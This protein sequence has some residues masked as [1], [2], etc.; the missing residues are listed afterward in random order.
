MGIPPR[1]VQSARAA[2][3]GA[4]A[5]QLILSNAPPWGKDYLGQSRTSEAWNV[6]GFARGAEALNSASSAAYAGEIW[7]R[8]QGRRTQS[9]ERS[10]V[11][12]LTNKKHYDSALEAAT[13][14]GI[15]DQSVYNSCNDK[16]ARKGFKFE[17]V[18]VDRERL[19]RREQG[20]TLYRRNRT[21]TG[22]KEGFFFVYDFPMMLKDLRNKELDVAAKERFLYMRRVHTLPPTLGGVHVSGWNDVLG[23]ITASEKPN[24]PM[25][26]VIL[27]YK[28]SLVGKVFRQDVVGKIYKCCRPKCAAP[29]RKVCGGKLHS[30]KFA[31][32]RDLLSTTPLR[33]IV[34][35]KEGVVYEATE[36][37]YEGRCGGRVERVSVEGGLLWVS[38]NGVSKFVHLVRERT[39]V[40][41]RR[42]TSFHTLF[43]S[44]DFTLYITDSATGTCLPARLE[45]RKGK[46]GSHFLVQ[47][48]SG[49]KKKEVGVR[50]R[51]VR[52]R[53]EEGGWVAFAAFVG[54]KKKEV[55]CARAKRG[56]K[57]TRV[58][59]VFKIIQSLGAWRLG[60]GCPLAEDTIAF[61]PDDIWR[62]AVGVDARGENLESKLIELYGGVL[63]SKEQSWYCLRRMREVPTK[64]HVFRHVCALSRGGALVYQPSVSRCGN[65]DVLSRH[66]KE[67]MYT[68]GVNDR[69]SVRDMYKYLVV[70][71]AALAPSSL[72]ELLGILNVL[73]VDEKLVRRISLVEF[74]LLE[75]NM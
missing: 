54:A 46:S 2:R 48:A 65:Y 26:Q 31:K 34:T 74:K 53:E 19:K 60:C 44:I 9:K 14:L 49:A 20:L 42:I 33:F 23:I 41:R 39:L 8:F 27:D 59:V 51:G 73:E 4:M 29:P 64:Y 62:R 7:R 24:L 16:R 28:R 56:G 6:L 72:T 57:E 58:D 45:L 3:P 38:C 21:H 18:T 66:C 68:I 32:S 47:R 15:S 40:N 22:T 69:F 5:V 50:V 25:Q 35:R 43:Y 63:R 37:M 52:R 30:G 75:H 61:T 70:K 1:R 11:K 13:E 36:L 67:G 71:C 12:C 17:W 10:G 55:V